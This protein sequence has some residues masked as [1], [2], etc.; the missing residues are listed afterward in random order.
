[1]NYLKSILI[2]I[3]LY[4]SS[5]TGNLIPQEEMS[6]IIADIY[7][8][9]RY[10]SSEYMMVLGSDTTKVYEAIFSN[11]G[12][13]SKN[14]V[15]TIEHYLS[16]PSKLKSIYSG[17]KDII[18]EEYNTVTNI[19]RRTERLDS[20]S[21]LYQKL[22]EN[23]DSVMM[24]LPHERALR[25]VMEPLVFPRWSFSYSDSIRNLY[26][27]PQMDIWWQNNFKKDTTT[28]KFTIID[29]KN[30]RTVPV[31]LKFHKAYLERACYPE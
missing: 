11:Y 7:R 27:T 25:W 23:R 10:V 17:A 30:S 13:S 22:I 21:A 2:I 15:N 19:I 8:A 29:E 4:T 3:L 16:R 18:A 5:C 20:I 12:Y 26:E 6:Q 24:L 28:L 1:M 14:F 9:D 31:P